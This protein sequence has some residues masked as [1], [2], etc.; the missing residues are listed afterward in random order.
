[1]EMREFGAGGAREPVLSTAESTE[2]NVNA[3]LPITTILL[4]NGIKPC[5]F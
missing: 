4:W 3:R 1:M 2:C 5:G